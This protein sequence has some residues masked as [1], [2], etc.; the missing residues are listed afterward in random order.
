M[1]WRIESESAV[2]WISF[3][4]PFPYEWNGGISWRQWKEKGCQL[5]KNRKHCG[6]ASSSEWEVGGAVDFF[7]CLAFKLC[8]TSIIF[9]LSLFALQSNI[10]V[11]GGGMVWVL[12]KGKARLEMEED[13]QCLFSFFPQLKFC[14]C[15][16]HDLEMKW[17]KGKQT[18]YKSQKVFQIVILLVSWYL[19]FHVNN[20]FESWALNLVL[21]FPSQSAV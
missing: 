7:P 15:W 16:S 8:P 13:R 21:L 12:G 2:G 5:G 6:K 10:R 3:Q 4:Y 18:C 19:H 20:T 17:L 9:S 14:L 1:G 11:C